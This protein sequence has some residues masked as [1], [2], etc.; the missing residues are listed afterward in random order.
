MPRKQL[1]SQK[2]TITLPEYV[3]EDIDDL[4]EEVGI[5]R[6]EVICDILR[7]VLKDKEILNEIFPFE[8]EGNE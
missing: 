8:D 6:S 5:T 4:S 2:V 3:V 1:K 7:A